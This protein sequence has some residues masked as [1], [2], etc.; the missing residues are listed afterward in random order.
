MCVWGDAAGDSAHPERTSEAR[1]GALV[2]LNPVVALLA[3]RAFTVVQ[4]VLAANLRLDDAGGWSTGGLWVWCAQV[5]GTESRVSPNAS[6][7]I[8]RECAGGVRVRCR[9]CRTSDVS[10]TRKIAVF[11][12]IVE[13]FCK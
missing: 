9:G 8:S 6:G 5:S 13:T 12:S 1:E 10:V 4:A 11:M 3:V 7:S 2:I